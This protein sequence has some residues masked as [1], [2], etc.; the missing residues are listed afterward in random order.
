MYVIFSL[1][2]RLQEK[3][4]QSY[5]KIQEEKPLNNEVDCL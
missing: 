5:T 4:V 2:I 3:T 1:H